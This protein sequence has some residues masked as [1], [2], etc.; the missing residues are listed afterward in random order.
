MRI[1]M[2]AQ[3]FSPIVGGEER[4]VE[5]LSHQLAGRG[6]E[7]AVAT[8]R[9]PLGEPPLRED[10]VEVELLETAMSRVPGLAA[11][12]ERAYAPPAPDPLTVRGASRTP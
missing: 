12:P 5:D 3:S 4:I 8:L 10:G 6:H 11:D 9:Q 1:L 7:V 2:V